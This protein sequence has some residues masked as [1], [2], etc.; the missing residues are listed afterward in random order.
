MCVFRG[1]DIACTV[2]FILWISQSTGEVENYSKTMSDKIVNILQ[3]I[4]YFQDY[5]F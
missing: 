5:V 1:N 2:Y 4:N 3:K